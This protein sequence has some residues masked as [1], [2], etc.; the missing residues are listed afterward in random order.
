MNTENP[1]RTEGSL[2]VLEAKP[3]K[4]DKTLPPP[5]NIQLPETW[6]FG[7]ETP[8]RLAEAIAFTAPKQALKVITE[9]Q[10]QYDATLK[11][12]TALS[13]ERVRLTVAEQEASAL[14]AIR[15][16]EAPNLKGE[17]ASRNQVR[18][19]QK[20]ESRALKNAL[21]T[22]IKQA[23]E[24]A[25]PL[26]EDFCA[27]ASAHVEEMARQEAELYDRFAVPVKLGKLCAGLRRAI[28]FV[29]D[30]VPNA[31]RVTMYQR[32]DSFFPW[33]DWQK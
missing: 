12:L 28:D 5:A 21:R 11:R 4:P 25:K 7:E 20:A 13:E 10:G 29:R 19:K 23:A 24:A 17:Y 9:A 2:A 30:L 26:N 3:P 22:I 16:G 14:T 6:S 32:P 18:E 15:A 1:Y 8:R 31:E 33:H 27:E